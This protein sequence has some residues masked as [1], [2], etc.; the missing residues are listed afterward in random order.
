MNTL[1]VEKVAS[2]SWMALSWQYPLFSLTPNFLIGAYRTRHEAIPTTW[3]IIEMTA[4]SCWAL[5]H[6][7]GS[8]RE[9]RIKITAASPLP[10][11][12]A[13]F[14]IRSESSIKQLKHSLRAQIPQLQTSIHSDSDF[15]LQLD[16]FA[17]LDNSDIDILRD[18]DSIA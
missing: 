5:A 18:G 10:P 6:C 1:V 11:L 13:W 9:M 4:C 17:L 15:H 7:L 16:E 12:K 14:N 8:Q 3:R 2:T